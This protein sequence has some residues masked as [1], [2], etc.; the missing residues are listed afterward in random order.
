MCICT[1]VTGLELAYQC[2]MHAL[3]NKGQKL[4]FK[5][6]IP[7]L[8]QATLMD[9]EVKDETL[10]LAMWSENTPRLTQPN[11]EP[12]Y[13]KTPAHINTCY[14]V[15]SLIWVMKAVLSLFVR[16]LTGWCV[17]LHGGSVSLFTVKATV[18]VLL[19][20]TDTTWHHIQGF[21]TLLLAYERYRIYLTYSDDS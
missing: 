2:K 1:C 7:G 18:L 17:S 19:I 3:K 8:T 21:C 6:G 10:S 16:L 11:A 12:H 5:P 9:R 20:K 15:G 4:L 14:P 13:K